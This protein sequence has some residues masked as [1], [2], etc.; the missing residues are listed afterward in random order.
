MKSRPAPGPAKTLESYPENLSLEYPAVK[1]P[2]VLSVK[3]L[4]YLPSRVSLLEVSSFL[5]CVSRYEEL[6]KYLFTGASFFMDAFTAKV[7]VSVLPEVFT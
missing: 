7:L 6:K 4:S 2:K 5:F 3:T 1:R